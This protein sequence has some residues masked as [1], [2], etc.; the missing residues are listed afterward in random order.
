MSDTALETNVRDQL[1]GDARVDASRIKIDADGGVVVLSG[2][3]DSL[4][5]KLPRRRT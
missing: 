5:E 2:V 4:H 1:S 3:V